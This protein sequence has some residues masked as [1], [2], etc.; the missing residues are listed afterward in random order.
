MVPFLWNILEHFLIARVSQLYVSELWAL[1]PVFGLWQVMSSQ[2]CADSPKQYRNRQICLCEHLR[3]TFINIQLF[4]NQRIF[5]VCV[6]FA[7]SGA[8]RVSQKIWKQIPLL[9]SQILFATSS[10]LTL[11]LDLKHL[12]SFFCWDHPNMR[13]STMTCKTSRCINLNST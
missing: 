8:T 12:A 3:R 4:N 2:C 11:T 9:V 10:M 13:S 6:V 7:L 5:F 1:L